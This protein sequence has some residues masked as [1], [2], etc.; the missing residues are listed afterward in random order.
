MVARWLLYLRESFHPAS[1]LFVS[2]LL[3]YLVWGLLRL[4]HAPERGFGELLAAALTYALMILYY[5]ICDEFKDADTDRE[6]FPERPVPSGRVRLADLRA[7]KHATSVV[8]FA[9][10]IVL[11]HAAW[12]FLGFWLFA[13]AMGRWF[14]LPRLISQNRLLAFVT[15]APIGLLGILYLLR[16]LGPEDI[17][18][19]KPGHLV[20]AFVLAGPGMVWEIL[21]KT[22]SPQAE[23]PGYQTYSSI[24]GTS[25]AMLLA[26]ALALAVM[27]LGIWVAPTWELPDWMTVALLAWHLTLFA[28]LIGVHRLLQRRE[29]DLRWLGEAYS[30]GLLLLFASGVLAA[31]WG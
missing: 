20:M 8:A 15:H 24:L 29:A 25:G 17:T 11:P 26:G 13:W 3:T 2:A 7:L 9:L 14:F 27:V 19:W 1:R 21:R 4:K 31:L 16:A 12:V 30:A 23:R 28:V 10:Q 5:R 6:Y 18:V 22:R